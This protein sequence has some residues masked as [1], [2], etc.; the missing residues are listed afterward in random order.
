M[1]P[2]KEDLLDALGAVEKSLTYLVARVV[3][4]DNVEVEEIKTCRM[5]QATV[6]DALRRSGR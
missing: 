4:V 3:P 1:E 5:V 2:T 6:A